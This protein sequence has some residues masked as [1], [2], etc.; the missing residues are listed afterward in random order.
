MSP[1]DPKADIAAGDSPNG[2]SW[3]IDMGSRTPLRLRGQESVRS[4][5]EAE[6]EPDLM[7]LAVLEVEPSRFFN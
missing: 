1:S 4:V 5:R 2:T 3:N 7:P 6:F